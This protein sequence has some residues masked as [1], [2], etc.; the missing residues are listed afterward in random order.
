[1]DVRTV[2]Q[3]GTCAINGLEVQAHG[4]V[5]DNR[6]SLMVPYRLS[7]EI[8]DLFFVVKSFLPIFFSWPRTQWPLLLYS[9]HRSVL[10]LIRYILL[11][12]S[13]QISWWL[14]CG[15]VFRVR[16]LYNKINVWSFSCLFVSGPEPKVTAIRDLLSQLSVH[17]Y[18]HWISTLTKPEGP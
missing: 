6:T 1:M 15:T 16:A 2:G 4:P 9:I 17:V 5:M 12:V 8:S 11:F 10:V 7:E 14:V 13:F 3:A 18:F